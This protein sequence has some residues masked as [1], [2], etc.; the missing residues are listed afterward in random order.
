M[1]FARAHVLVCGGTGCTSSGSATIIEEFEKCLK[2]N[3]L[4]VIEDVAPISARLI[5]NAAGMKLR[6][7]EIEELIVKMK[8]CIKD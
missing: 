6:K 2:E 5:V 8:S 7:A 1:D 4:E 3:G